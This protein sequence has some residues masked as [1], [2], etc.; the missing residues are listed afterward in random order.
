MSVKYVCQHF[1]CK[2]DADVYHYTE[3]SP[4]EWLCPEHAGDE[5]FC[6]GCGYF[7]AGT[8]DFDFSPSKGLCGQCL[9]H[10]R[11]EVGEYDDPPDYEY[12]GYLFY[13]HPFDD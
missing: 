9:D 5:G 4:A 13:G 10:L 12:S 11:H 7:L 2:E 1:N 8:E 3:D 6:Y